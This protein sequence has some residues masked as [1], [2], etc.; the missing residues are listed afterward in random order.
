MTRHQH[1]GWSVNRMMLAVTIVFGICCSLDFLYRVLRL[2]GAAYNSVIL[3]NCYAAILLKLS[4]HFEVMNSSA[5]FIIYGAMSRRFRQEAR[6]IIISCCRRRTTSTP[7]P[8]L[9]PV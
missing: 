8:A 9:P 5:N 1:Q 2:A 3:D 6:D 4:Y 7:N